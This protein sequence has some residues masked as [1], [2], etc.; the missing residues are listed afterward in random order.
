M[1]ISWDRSSWWRRGRGGGG[2]G[3]AL[4]QCQGRYLHHESM[5]WKILKS[6]E[7]CL[8]KNEN[9]GKTQK[10]HYRKTKQRLIIFSGAGLQILTLRLITELSHSSSLANSIFHLLDNTQSYPSGMSFSMQQTHH[11]LVADLHVYNRV[12]AHYWGR[13]T[14]IVKKS[15]LQSSRKIHIHQKNTKT[16]RNR[17]RHDIHEK[18]L[19]TKKIATFNKYDKKLHQKRQRN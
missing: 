10:W 11:P 19:S 14:K 15:K 9:H 7:Y 3:G 16:T 1:S 13:P 17:G 2:D 8:D 18:T 12:G 6:R 4:I 5:D